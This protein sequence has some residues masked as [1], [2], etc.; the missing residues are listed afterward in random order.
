[1]LNKRHFIYK[2]YFATTSR[3]NTEQNIEQNT[4]KPT[5]TKCNDK[6]KTTNVK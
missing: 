3:Y 2:L 4:D 6:E 5:H 1:L